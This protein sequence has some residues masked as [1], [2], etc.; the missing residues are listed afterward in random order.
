VIFYRKFFFII[1]EGTIG[2]KR[3]ILLIVG[4]LLRKILERAQIGG[5]LRNTESYDLENAILENSNVKH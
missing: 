3:P 2:K 4:K 5:T 1:F